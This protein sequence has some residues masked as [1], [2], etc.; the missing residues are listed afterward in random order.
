MD[1]DPEGKVAS[2]TTVGVTVATVTDHESLSSLG[3]IR[4]DIDSSLET[5]EPL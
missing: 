5:L 4:L 1:A 3:K 2:S